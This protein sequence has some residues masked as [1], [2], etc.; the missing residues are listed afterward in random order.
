MLEG[1]IVHYFMEVMSICGMPS[2]GCSSGPAAGFSEA[3]PSTTTLYFRLSSQV[4]T[5]QGHD[6]RPNSELSYTSKISPFSSLPESR[7]QL[8]CI[9]STIR[10][11]GTHHRTIT[12]SQ[13]SRNPCSAR[14]IFQPTR[15]RPERSRRFNTT[16][17]I[18][19]HPGSRNS[20]PSPPRYHRPSNCDS[21]KILVR[22]GWR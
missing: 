18:A 15:R 22:T 8:F 11:Y 17:N 20:T 1:Q 10:Q 7:K 21:A 13:P 16:W 14:N 4:K 2:N 9:T 3:A 6:F 12:S 19:P 5:N